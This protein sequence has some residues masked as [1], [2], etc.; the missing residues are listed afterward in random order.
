MKADWEFIDSIQKKIGTEKKRRKKRLMTITCMA[1]FFCLSVGIAI[2]QTVPGNNGKHTDGNKTENIDVSLI[3][4]SEGISGEDNHGLADISV[5]EGANSCELPVEGKLVVERVSNLNEVEKN[6]RRAEL[7]ESL[8]HQWL[9]DKRRYYINGT[10][11]ENYIASIAIQGDFVIRVDGGNG[12]K[13]RV[14][15]GENGTI[16]TEGGSD[17]VAEGLDTLVFHYDISEKMLEKFERNPETKYEDIQDEIICK[18]ES[19][20]QRIQFFIIRIH[21]DTDGYMR[22]EYIEGNEV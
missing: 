22:A 13:I 2:W 5:G 14:E 9:I 8:T 7:N 12:T 21:F 20:E 1:L 17:A 16:W 11:S 15:C 19:E 10:Q 18:I 4:Y 6:N 3:L